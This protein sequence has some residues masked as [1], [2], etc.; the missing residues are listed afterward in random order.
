MLELGFRVLGFQRL[1]ISCLHGQKVKL[2]LNSVLWAEWV[3]SSRSSEEALAKPA[4]ETFKGA[5]K[6]MEC[7]KR[8][9]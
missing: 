5:Q 3:L 4:K 2:F 1:W 6:L 9:R 8:L 7:G